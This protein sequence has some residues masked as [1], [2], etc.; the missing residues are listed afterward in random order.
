MAVTALPMLVCAIV[1]FVP[2]ITITPPGDPEPSE[3]LPTVVTVR[4]MI[5][6]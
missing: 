6:Y 3:I 5:R 4:Q 2:E 1:V